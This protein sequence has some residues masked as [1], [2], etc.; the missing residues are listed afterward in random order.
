M[1]VQSRE[2]ESYPGF[3]KK[4]LLRKKYN[5]HHKKLGVI[6]SRKLEVGALMSILADLNRC[7]GG[8]CYLN[9]AQN[10]VTGGFSLGI[11][12]PSNVQWSIIALTF[13]M[14]VVTPQFKADPNVSC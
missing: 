11:T 12:W 4:T 2:L 3:V 6:W 14:A 5:I 9:H 1:G 13:K 10:A 7:P 8:F